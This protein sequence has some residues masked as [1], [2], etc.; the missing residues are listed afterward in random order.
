MDA[1]VLLRTK[2]G[3]WLGALLPRGVW[4]H[5]W[6]SAVPPLSKASGVSAG[7]EGWK[8]RCENRAREVVELPRG[9]VLNQDSG[10]D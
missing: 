9:L 1:E 6:G 8:W 10:L 3:R 7:R 4:G 2:G 5:G